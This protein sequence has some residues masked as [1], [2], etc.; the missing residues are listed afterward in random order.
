MNDP[1]IVHAI[2][3]K[4][5]GKVISGYGTGIKSR[6]MTLAHERRDIVNAALKEFEIDWMIQ[7]EEIKEAIP[8]A[9][10]EYIG[11]YLLEWIRNGD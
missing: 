1:V 7:N 8:P 10:T 6:C 4:C 11:R 5:R 3:G 9:Y 2:I